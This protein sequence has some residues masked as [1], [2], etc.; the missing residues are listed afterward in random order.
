[1]STNSNLP[2]EVLERRAQEQRARIGESVSELK[3]SLKETVRQRLDV[4]SFAQKHMWQLAGVTSVL[5]LATGYAV[6]GM[7]TRH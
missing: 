2:P 4:N 7:F 5:A 6:A 3:V 1:M